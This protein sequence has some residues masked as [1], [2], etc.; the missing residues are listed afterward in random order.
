MESRITENSGTTFLRIGGEVKVQIKSNT[1]WRF[2]LYNLLDGYD[3]YSIRKETYIDDEGIEQ[4]RFIGIDT[5]STPDWINVVDDYGV[6][7]KSITGSN[8][9]YITIV[10]EEN[11]TKQDQYCVGIVKSSTYSYMGGFTTFLSYGKT[12][13][14]IN[15]DKVEDEIVVHTPSQVQ[16]FSGETLY[17]NYLSNTYSVTGA[18]ASTYDTTIIPFEIYTTTPCNVSMEGAVETYVVNK[19]T[20]TNSGKTVTTDCTKTGENGVVYYFKVPT[21]KSINDINYTIKAVSRE[22]NTVS[23]EYTVVFKGM[24]SEIIL[25]APKTE[26][27]AEDK[28][29][30]VNYSGIPST[31]VFNLNVHEGYARN[32][33]EVMNLPIIYTLPSCN[34]TGSLSY[35]TNEN[36]SLEGR[37][38]YIEGSAI[39]NPELKAH[40][41]DNIGMYYVAIG[42][43]STPIKTIEIS[44]PLRIEESD[45]SF[46][47]SYS[48]TPNDFNFNLYVWESGN[49]NSPTI[50]NVSGEGTETFNCGTNTAT[51]ERVFYASASTIDEQV[52]SD[53]VI[54]TQAGVTPIERYFRFI[55]NN[56]SAYTPTTFD[57]T[58]ASTSYSY[59]TNYENLTISNTNNWITGVTL[60]NNTININV[61]ENFEIISRSGIINIYS[62]STLIGILTINQSG[63]TPRFIFT[64]NNSSAYTPTAYSSTG[65]ITSVAY[66][67]NIP[68]LTISYN[69]NWLTNVSLNNGNINYTIESNTG[70]TRSSNIYIKSNNI[71]VGILTINQNEATRQVTIKF[72][73]IL[74]VKIKNLPQ[75][76]NSATIYINGVDNSWECYN[77]ENETIV[78]FYNE[79]IYRPQVTVPMGATTKEFTFTYEPNGGSGNIIGDEWMSGINCRFDSDTGSGDQPFNID[80]PAN[81]STV[82]LENLNNVLIITYT[83]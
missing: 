8:S 7:N 48:G 68:S 53:R 38:F 18:T 2:N 61:L 12:L 62:D 71:N 59:E 36:E 40:A 45:S 35:Q 57:S 31:M 60:N 81:V 32:Y 1:N 43:A 78:D 47:V 26:L 11:L 66:E 42:Q 6:K 33:E 75:S 30:I 82:T 65:T 55:A 16:F 14:I 24:A 37:T 50:Y 63:A 77:L 21:N 73:N 46:A 10:A 27:T 3:I 67:T 83:R 22:D 5:A 20:T 69:D 15:F 17:F 13:Q 76:V 39:E 74:K 9:N 79:H 34:G 25:N 19:G 64:A 70:T 58:T 4:I 41:Q 44:A 80:I 56:S 23:E 54:I 49:E 28:Q 29:F 72:P 51:T 52:Q